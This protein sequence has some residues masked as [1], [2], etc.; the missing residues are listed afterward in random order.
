[1]PLI[2]PL[3]LAASLLHASP[4]AKPHATPALICETAGLRPGTQAWVAVDF[5][6]EKGWHLY[7]NGRNDTGSPPQVKWTL[8]PGFTAGEMLWPAPR[9]HVVEGGAEGGV[10]DHIYEKALTLLMPI[11]VPA[12]AVPGTEVEITA[13]CQWVVCQDACVFEKATVSLRLKVAAEKPELSGTFGAFTA[14][15]AR[16]PGYGK[17]NQGITGFIKDNALVVEAPGAA[18]ICFFPADDSAATPRLLEQG[19]AKGPRLRVDVSPA[20]GQAVRGVVAI[21][22][23]QA[24]PVTVL[25]VDSSVVVSGGPEGRSVFPLK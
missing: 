4:P 24:R 6:I 21:R 17:P 22:W 5:A 11:T 15:R 9:R 23:A 20:P 13:D 25:I 10:V 1:M 12:D 2:A 3:L 19:E 8:P 16:Q 7:W 14:A 18:S